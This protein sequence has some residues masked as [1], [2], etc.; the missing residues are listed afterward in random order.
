MGKTRERLEEFYDELRRILQGQIRR[1]FPKGNSGEV[2]DR[3]DEAAALV[4]ISILARRPSIRLLATTCSPLAYLLKCG[5]NVLRHAPPKKS[6]L[7]LKSEPIEAD[8]TTPSGAAPT[9]SVMNP[10]DG[11]L[12]QELRS[13]IALYPQPKRAIFVLW[14]HGFTS[15]EIARTIRVTAANARYHISRM[16]AELQRRGTG[17]A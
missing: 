7:L 3:A 9:T 13:K 4:T 11:L 8:G 12:I 15:R 5:W 17:A 10:T 14:M 2:E 1:L 16:R 6:I